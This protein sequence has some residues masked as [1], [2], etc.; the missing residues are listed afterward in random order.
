VQHEVNGLLVPRASADGLAAA[1]RR[2]ASDPALRLQL[3]KA[4]R[5][6]VAERYAIGTIAAS[7]H[8]LYEA[9]LDV[10]PSRS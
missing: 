8:K 9:V 10:S 7:F 1:M 4:A 6:S 3:G 2:L 5:E